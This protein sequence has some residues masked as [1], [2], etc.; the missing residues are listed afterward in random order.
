MS[1]GEEI[2]VEEEQTVLAFW[3]CLLVPAF[4]VIVVG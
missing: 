1:E 3:V 4:L 2:K